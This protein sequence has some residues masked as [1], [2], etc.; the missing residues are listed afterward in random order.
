MSIRRLKKGDDVMVRTGRDKGKR[1]TVIQVLED[2]RVLVEGVNVVKRH[3]RGNPQQG[4]AGGII[5]KELPIH[6]SNVGIYNPTK[7]G[8]DRMGVK[9]LEDGRRVRLFKSTQEVVDV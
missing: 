3:T 6:I 8:P 4:T 9:T 2:D 5:E 7:G 1:G